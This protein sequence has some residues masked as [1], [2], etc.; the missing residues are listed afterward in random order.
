MSI[1]LEGDD[2]EVDSDIAT[3]VALIINELLQNSLQYAFEDRETGLIRIVVTRG[4][5]YSRIE[6]IDNGGGYDVENVRTD[7]LDSPLSRR[8]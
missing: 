7:R 5:L 4:E 6:V 3:S 2:F 1:T 8:W